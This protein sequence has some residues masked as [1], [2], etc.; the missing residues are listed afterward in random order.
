MSPVRRRRLGVA[1]MPVDPG[2]VEAA[3]GSTTGGETLGLGGGAG[4]APE[5]GAVADPGAGAGGLAGGVPA[6]GGF[7]GCCPE[8]APGSAPARSLLLA[9][10]GRLTGLLPA[11]GRCRLGLREGKGPWARETNR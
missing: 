5:G 8:A 3:G 11:G 7:A 4:G 9:G 2:W 6:G 10:R 1:V